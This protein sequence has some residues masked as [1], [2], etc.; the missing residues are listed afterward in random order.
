MIEVAR[1]NGGHAG[2][3]EQAPSDYPEM[4][5]FLVDLG[6]DSISFAPDRLMK[7]TLDVLAVEK[8]LRGSPRANDTAEGLPSSRLDDAA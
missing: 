7:I 6:I 1:R 2:I 5:Q 3:C 8:R 4:A